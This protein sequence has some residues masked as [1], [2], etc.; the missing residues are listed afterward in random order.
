MWAAVM[1]RAVLRLRQAAAAQQEAQ[2]AAQH[3]AQQLGGSSPCTA[4]AA[5][6]AA[7]A[8]A[9]WDCDVH[10]PAWV[11]DNEAN[12]VRQRLE[13]WVDQLLEVC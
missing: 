6:A 4:A 11:S 12:T 2:Q 1:N 7:T 8:D 10:L 5:S 3:A 13:G 9:A